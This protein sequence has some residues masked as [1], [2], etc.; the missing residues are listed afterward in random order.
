MQKY[1]NRYYN[2]YPAKPHEDFLLQA[3]AFGEFMEQ[4]LATDEEAADS[5]NHNLAEQ[6]QTCSI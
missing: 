1:Y 2:L 5:H 4:S 3:L 6:F